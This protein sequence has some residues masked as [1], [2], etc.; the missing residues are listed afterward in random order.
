MTLSNQKPPENFLLTAQ[1]EITIDA[2]AADEASDGK[3]SLPRFSMVAYTGG[4]MRIAG[5]RHPVVVDLAGLAIPSQ[6]RPIRFGHDANSGVGHSDSIRV[7]GGN[8]IATGVISRDTGAAREVVASSK[9]GFPWQASIGASVEQFEFVKENESVIVNGRGFT[10]PVNVVRKSVLGEISFVDLGADGNTSAN[11]AASA[12][13]TS[14]SQSPHNQEKKPMTITAVADE[15]TTADT[16]TPTN[17]PATTVQ[18]GMASTATAITSAS[19]SSPAAVVASI[20]A[21]DP[22]TQMRQRIAAETR[23]IDA[24]R[25]LC[26]GKHSAIEAR[27]IEEG[28]D[29]SRTELE[30]LRDA[31][32]KVANIGAGRQ[33]ASSP[34]VFE[35]AGLMAAGVSMS[36]IE[37]TY[38]EPVLEAA[39]RMRGVGIQEFCEIVCGQ[40]LPRFRSDASGWLQAA[41]STA[42]LPG[43][44]SNIANKMLLEGYNYVEDAWRRIAKIASVNDFKEHSRYR[45][46]GGFTFVQVGAD[47]ELKHGKIDE[48]KF[49]QKADTHGIMFSLTR[50]MII[51]DD[52][53]AFTDIPRQ[54]GMGAAEAIADAV[55]GLWLRNPVCNDGKPF[56]A[57]DHRNFADGAD[58][59]LT[60]DGLT[61]AEVTFGEQVK[62]N[63]RPLG[64]PASILLVPTALKVPA[65]MLMKSVLLNENTTTPKPS[66]NP[67]TG[68]FEVVSSVYLSSA[69]FTGHSSKAWYLLSDPNRLPAIEIAFLNGV[70]RPTVEKTDADFNTLGI[71]FRGYIDFG[72]REQDFRGA[73]KMRSVVSDLL[74]WRWFRRLVVCA[75]SGARGWSSTGWPGP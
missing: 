12:I 55:W 20:S 16:T 45:M 43:I 52:M 22:V 18:A 8:L 17:T 2:A 6:A 36:R 51:N 21:D 5:W 58:T 49:G 44:L 73:L 71:A 10:G 37:A 42:S 35:A 14:S 68:K 54:I 3:A 7:E 26:A 19:T 61:K 70:D 41:F 29:T 69:A 32:P 72:V 39:N 23:R 9:N 27:A 66:A 28:W 74:L 13:E 67:H 57:T 53:G 48:M 1:M 30:V 31:R 64:I 63:G 15:T 62:P 33:Q 56:F 25:A 40:Q 4:T 24:I 60:V 34:Q 47:G 46:T 59:A 75:S 50:Q 11:V 65:E 38:A